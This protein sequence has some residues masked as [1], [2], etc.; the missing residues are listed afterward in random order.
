LTKKTHGELRDRYKTG[1]LAIQY[2]ITEF[3]LAS[4]LGITV[5][6]AREMINQHKQLFTVYWQWIED[7]TQHAF[8]SG[9]MWTPFGWHCTVGITEHNERSVA[10]F[11]IQATSADIL[12]LA[13]IMAGRRGIRMLAPVHD[14]L[15]IEASIVRIEADVARMQKIMKRAFGKSG[16]ATA[17][18]SCPA[19]LGQPQQN[20]RSRLLS[21]GIHLGMCLMGSRPQPRSETSN[22]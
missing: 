12:R 22:P 9:E 10:N 19:S 15:L 8:T 16:N 2:G 13:I 3:T 7:W 11:A 1:L 6:A 4:R 5:F 18:R 14:A 21:H 17:R 20:E